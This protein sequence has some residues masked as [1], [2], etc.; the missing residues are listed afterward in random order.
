MDFMLKFPFSQPFLQDVESASYQSL[1]VIYDCSSPLL[2]DGCDVQIFF[3]EHFKGRRLKFFLLPE[4]LESEVV[5]VDR[6]VPEAVGRGRAADELDVPAR[7]LLDAGLRRGL[8]AVLDVGLHDALAD[9]LLAVELVKRVKPGD[10]VGAAFDVDE[11]RK[12]LRLP[13]SQFI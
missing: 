13:I 5:E 11:A 10:A 9:H 3:E 4:C 12:L 6:C 8:D 2:L 1:I 7:Q